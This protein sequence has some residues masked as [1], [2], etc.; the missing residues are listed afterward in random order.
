MAENNLDYV[1]FHCETVSKGSFGLPE[2]VKLPESTYRMDLTLCPWVLFMYSIRTD[3]LRV[4]SESDK[5]RT[6]EL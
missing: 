6:Y 2:W 1:F 4:A 5:P 3:R